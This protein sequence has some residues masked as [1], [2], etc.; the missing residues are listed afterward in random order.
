MGGQWLGP[1]QENSYSQKGG[2]MTQRSLQVI[3]EPSDRRKRKGRSITQRSPGDWPTFT[4]TRSSGVNVR[5]QSQW[6]GG[7]QRRHSEPAGT[8]AAP[9]NVRIIERKPRRSRWPLGSAER[10]TYGFSLLA[11]ALLRKRLL[12]LA[13][14]ESCCARQRSVGTEESRPIA[15]TNCVKSSSASGEAGTERLVRQTFA[16][17]ALYS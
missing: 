7:A 5:R 3:I 8:L 14:P 13:A 9:A 1:A 12:V 10:E 6:C 4:A 17:R 16:K 11:H 2:S 15:S